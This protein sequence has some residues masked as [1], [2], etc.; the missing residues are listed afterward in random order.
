MVHLRLS[1]NHFSG[2]IPDAWAFPGTYRK[3]TVLSLGANGLTGSLPEAWGGHG[4]FP[5]LEDFSLNDNFM[6]GTIPDSWALVGAF[7]TFVK[8]ANGS[9]PFPAGFGRNGERGSM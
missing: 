2:P 8:N 3:L 5:S 1:N 7:S 9:A 4:R 6:E